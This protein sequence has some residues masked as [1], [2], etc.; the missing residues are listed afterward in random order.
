MSHD[1]IAHLTAFLRGA[2]IGAAAMYM[3]DPDKGRRRRALAADKA[4]RFMSDASTVL[5]AAAHDVSNRVRGVQAS[6]GRRL[7][8]T[9][10]PD[11]LQL[12]E[13]VRARIGRVV[14]H[15]HAIQVGA[16][17]GEVTLSGPVLMSEVDDLVEAAWSVPGVV[18]VDEHF[19]IH[20]SPGGMPSLQ[21]AGRRSR[22]RSGTLADNGG[23][24]LRAAAI[25][26][27]SLLAAYGVTQRSLSGLALAGIGGALASRGAQPV[28][29][30]PSSRRSAAPKASSNDATAPREDH[31]NAELSGGEPRIE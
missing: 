27:G 20:P 1:S 23:L 21:G 24:M 15:P 29:S 6:A 17:E 12:I 3:L 7:R 22:A 8:G 11:D 31:A 14:S 28:G 5:G 16:R 26:G 9:A 13:R 18:A 19:D 30:R 2:A 4:Q 25:V 10:T